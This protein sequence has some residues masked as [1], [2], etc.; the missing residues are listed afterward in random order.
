MK[1]NLAD[2]TLRNLRA[3][4]KTLRLLELRVKWLEDVIEWAL[5]MGA[6]KCTFTGDPMYAFPEKPL[7][8]K[9]K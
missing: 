1:R 3:S 4:K 7:K 5:D 2:L 8:K 9:T 6:M